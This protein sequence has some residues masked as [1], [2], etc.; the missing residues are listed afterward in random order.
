VDDVQVISKRLHFLNSS[1]LD[2]PSFIEHLQ[3]TTRGWRK[4]PEAL[5]CAKSVEATGNSKAT[6]TA[7]LINVLSFIS[8]YHFYPVSFFFFFFSFLLKKNSNSNKHRPE[9]WNQLDRNWNQNK[10]SVPF[11]FSALVYCPICSLFVLVAVCS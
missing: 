10:V 8:H 6:S 3:P 2:L 7:R 9:N 5:N 11:C 4:R 1:A